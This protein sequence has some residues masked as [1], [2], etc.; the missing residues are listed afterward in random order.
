M[1]FLSERQNEFLL[2]ASQT[3]EGFCLIS[4]VWDLNFGY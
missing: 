4:S 1:S 3:K 2:I